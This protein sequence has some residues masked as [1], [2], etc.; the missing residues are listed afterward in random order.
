V[1]Q[2]EDVIRSQERTQVLIEMMRLTHD[3]L[4]RAID[5]YM[6]AIRCHSGKQH[7]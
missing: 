6:E 7:G 3:R 1:S 2:C 4:E 5:R